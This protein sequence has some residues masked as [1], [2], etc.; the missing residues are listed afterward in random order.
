MHLFH[1]TSSKS[2]YIAYLSIIDIFLCMELSLIWAASPLVG[3]ISLDFNH[4]RLC[5]IIH[6]AFLLILSRGGCL[7]GDGAKAVLSVIL[8]LI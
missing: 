1:P 7:F 8:W 4:V 6:G 3:F 2:K 5:K